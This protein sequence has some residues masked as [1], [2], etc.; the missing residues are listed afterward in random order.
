MLK[1]KKIDVPII[2]CCIGL[3]VFSYILRERLLGSVALVNFVVYYALYYGYKQKTMILPTNASKRFMTFMIWV[4]YVLCAAFILFTVK[5][6]EWS[7]IRKILLIFVYILPSTFVTCSIR[8]NELTEHYIAIW[9]GFLQVICRTMCVFWIADKVLGNSIQKIWVNLY[10]SNTLASLVRSGRFV[11]Y[12]G[13]SLENTAIFIMLL[14][15]TTIYKNE[16]PSQKNTYILDVEV[17][18]F[19][20]AICGSKSGLILAL[21]LVLLCNVGLKKTKYMIAILLLFGVLYISGIFDLVISRLLDGIAIGDL[22][23]AR[24]SAL[25]TLMLRGIISFDFYKGHPFKYNDVAMTA[26]LEYP[27]LQWSFTCGI[28][29]T[30]VQY[31][32][33]FVYPGIRVLLSKKWCVLICMLVL[34]AF[35]NGNNGIVSFNDDLLMYSINIWLIVQVAFNNTVEEKHG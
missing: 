14:I 31:L 16:Y 7:T 13:H 18:I 4:T 22:S 1:I 35:Y 30:I 25:E 27:F 19:G 12:F 9:L 29:F 28:L 10:A 17:S 23:T 26:A 2:L 34:M 6:N 33:Y 3:F 24:N 11:S 5:G 8:K 20:I 15:W 21:L 32:M